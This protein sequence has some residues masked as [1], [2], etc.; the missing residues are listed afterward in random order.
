MVSPGG[1]RRGRFVVS[2]VREWRGRSAL[3][4][5][6]LALAALVA[7]AAVVGAE[8]QLSSVQPGKRYRLEVVATDATGTSRPDVGSTTSPAARTRVP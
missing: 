6:L 4:A 2:P 7:D 3:V 1:A 8:P 5:M